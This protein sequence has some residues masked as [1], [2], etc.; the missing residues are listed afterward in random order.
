MDEAEAKEKK[1]QAD[2]EAAVQKELARERRQ[3]KTVRRGAI[4]C[5]CHPPAIGR[6]CAVW[7]CWGVPPS[8]MI[9]VSKCAWDNDRLWPGCGAD[10]SEL[11]V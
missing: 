3:K 10:F 6:E 11:C 1:L 8:A 5:H 9:F 7:C 4:A 2:I